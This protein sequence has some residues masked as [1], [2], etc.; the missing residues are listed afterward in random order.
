[1]VTKEKKMAT[2]VLDDVNIDDLP[3]KWLKKLKPS[4]NERF[5]VTIQS[6]TNRSKQDLIKSLQRGREVAKENN[7]NIEEV[8]E[9]LGAKISHIL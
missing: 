2:L 7:I 6:K 4:T 9:I 3:K 1:M 5:I 8:E